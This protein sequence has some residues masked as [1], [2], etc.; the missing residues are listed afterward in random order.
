MIPQLE[1]RGL[2]TLILEI[3]VLFLVWALPAGLV[4]NSARLKGRTWASIF[5]SGLAFSW[6]LTGFTTALLAGKRHESELTP[7][8]QCESRIG[9]DASKCPNCQATRSSDLT[10]RD[11]QILNLVKSNQRLK[12]LGIL[13]TLV[14][15][16]SFILAILLGLSI[17]SG[18]V[19]S[20][21]LTV[22]V[23][24]VLVA[25]SLLAALVTAAAWGAWVSREFGH[26]LR[27]VK[28]AGEPHFTTKAVK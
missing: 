19:I 2:F 3:V 25:L 23:T 4:A 17:K 15:I 16:G 26:P 22:K 6:L 11:E 20:L 27:R 28:V 13:A 21:E 10:W 12:K 9:R 7:C 1:I 14:A 8:A 5:F 24:A 18:G